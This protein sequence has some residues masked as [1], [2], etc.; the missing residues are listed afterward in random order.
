MANKYFTIMTTA[1]L[2]K[3]ANATLLGTKLTFSK[4]RLGDGNGSHYEPTQDM[5][6]IKKQVYEGNIGTIEADK[7]NANW[8]TI[9]CTVP[10]NQGDFTIREIGLYDD[11]DTLVAIGNYPETYKPQIS[12][13]A[14][15]D[16]IIKLVIE[17]SNASSVT[18]KIDPAITLATKEEVLKIDERVKTNTKNI[19]QLSN[20]NLL[21]NED[22]QVWQRGTTFATNSQL[23]YSADRWK[24]ARNFQ[25]VEKTDAGI[26]ITIANPTTPGAGITQQIEFDKKYTGSDITLSV[27]IK[28]TGS[29]YF[30]VRSKD[31]TTSYAEKT[32]GS[33]V[34]WTIA[35]VTGKVGTITDN[36]ISIEIS[37]QTLENNT[38]E[39][40]W[41][42]LE[43]GKV[44]TP[45]VPRSYGEELA[46]CQRYYEV[47]DASAPLKR[48]S[49]PFTNT[50]TALQLGEFEYF[51]VTKRTKPTVTF[52]YDTNDVA[53]QSSTQ[54]FPFTHGFV[55]NVS[56]PTN[57][58]L[59]INSWIADAE[60]Y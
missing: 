41:V 56:V 7:N 30:A 26:K 28:N 8:I 25:R 1:G 29:V 34:D 44:A 20:P 43:F 53:E 51:A 45:F 23:K 24:I 18:L 17:V 42:K 59:D 19:A 38:I 33:N 9:T 57:Q 5:T 32:I 2:N 21:I 46:L 40:A 6:A 14:S 35:S 16:L 4:F 10:A 11:T 36:I 12:A 22:F 15:K 39:I 48:I 55:P 13:G 54:T 52:K 50:R 49:N 3:M 58:F 27:K 37:Q 31:F 47:S 60:I